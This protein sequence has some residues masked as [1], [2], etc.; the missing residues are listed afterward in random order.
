MSDAPKRGRGRPP[1]VRPPEN[2]A[3]RQGYFDRSRSL[4]QMVADIQSDLKALRDEFQSE[5]GVD[6]APIDKAVALSMKDTPE[7]IQTFWDIV[8]AMEE[9][10]IVRFDAKGQG[11]VFAALEPPDPRQTDL[12]EYMRV[13]A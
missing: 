8:A 4:R 7:A 5:H 6:T 2:P 13:V 10:N 1:K 12:E 9:F 3:M 11:N